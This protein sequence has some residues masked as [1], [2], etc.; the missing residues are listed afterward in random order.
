MLR[1]GSPLHVLSRVMLPSILKVMYHLKQWK[2]R[3]S[4][5]QSKEQIGTTISAVK[6]GHIKEACLP[7]VSQ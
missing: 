5:I 7:V 4:C 1:L 6:M 2:V 3:Q